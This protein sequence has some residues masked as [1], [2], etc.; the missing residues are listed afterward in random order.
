VALGFG[1]YHLGSR[2]LWGD[3]AFSVALARRP[4]G[5]FWH[6]VA[7]SQANM[8]LYYVVLRGWTALG[9]GEAVVRLLSL[10]AGLL[11]VAVFH[12]V[13]ERLFDRRV[14][15]FAALLLAV[16]GF[17]LRYAQE[18]RSY[19]LTLLLTT[20]ATLLFLLLDERPDAWG[21]GMAYVAV[22][23]LAVYAHFFAAF[24][25]VGHLLSLAVTGRPLGA[26]GIR[27]AVVGVMAIPLA[28]FALFRDV[29]QISH[30]TRPTPTY[31]EYTL[32]QLTGGTRLLL[33]L[34][35]AAVAVAVVRWVR[36]RSWL[37]DWPMVNAAVWAATPLVGSLVISL[38]KPLFAPRFLIVALPGIVLLVAVGLTRL[39]LPVAASGFVALVALSSVHVVRTLGKPQE[40]FRAATAF[41]LANDRP[42]D[43]VAFYRTSRRIPFEYYFRRLRV[44][45]PPRS[46]LPT[47][48]YGRFDMVTDYRHT[49]LTQSELAMIADAASRG[50]VWLFL[51]RS[52]NE[53]ARA[54]QENRARLVAAVEQSADLRRRHLF[55]G[56]DIRLYEPKG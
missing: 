38:G 23:A 47:S 50:R 28:L 8:S 53:Q 6:V 34:Y 18:A 45:M 9:D 3:E 21:V 31:V 17:F 43:A 29:G 33:V 55:A 14:A 51:S 1:L 11:A 27:L 26:Q 22:G 39:P 2:S 35:A 36:Q 12:A 15:T 4:F 7:T 48:P 42:G 40:D 10:L 56:L 20:V 19:S 16:N 41:V 49:E 54:K 37:R 25:L 5:E 13:G 46:L 32:R 52:E 24:V 30:L 44:G